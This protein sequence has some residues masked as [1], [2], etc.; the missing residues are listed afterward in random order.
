MPTR[1]SPLGHG[2]HTTRD[3]LPPT[4]RDCEGYVVSCSKHALAGWIEQPSACCAAAA[5]AGAVNA[6][7]GRGRATT[8][9]DA[10][11]LLQRKLGDDVAQIR[12]RLEPALLPLEDLIVRSRGEGDVVA[13]LLEL[14]G[15][16]V[17]PPSRAALARLR[18]IE[19][20][21]D[22]RASMAP[23]E[24]VH[25]AHTHK[26]RRSK[27]STGWTCDGGRE[28][29]CHVAN[30]GSGPRYRCSEGC[31]FDLCF[32]CWARAVAPGRAA[33]ADAADDEL[34]P[35]GWRASLHQWHFKLNGIELL[36]RDKP[37]TAKV[38]NL[39]LLGAVAL[40]NAPDEAP[41]LEAVLLMGLPAVGSLAGLPAVLLPVSKRDSPEYISKQ[42]EVL[43]RCVKADGMAVI[44]HLTNHYALVFATR[45]RRT[46]DADGSVAIARE[47]L[48]SKAGQAPKTW[49]PFATAR[50]I[51]RGWSGYKMVLVMRATERE[52]F[53]A[54]TA[55]MAEE[56][57]RSVA[58]SGS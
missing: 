48:T 52:A 55:V 33:T 8:L 1:C 4:L 32:A 7:R 44:F 41:E 38:G 47:L 15:S 27:R 2:L 22:R 9:R 23:S 16:S 49:I 56:E 21:E 25:P 19:A 3:E 53:T 57:R 54:Q 26:L 58:T 50:K 13:R 11:E 6:A 20:D 34:A 14:D 29:G 28:C 51:M 36:R 45:E 46:V 10:L 12:S 31:D 24:G 17:E 30:S 18:E 42:W 43:A 39:D 35:S 37:L 5:L 40:L